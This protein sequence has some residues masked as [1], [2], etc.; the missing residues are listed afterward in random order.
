MSEYLVRTTSGR[1]WPAIPRDKLAETLTI[2]GREC[3]PV[4]GSNHLRL[5]CGDADITFT[6]EA[7]GWQ[8]SVDGHLDDPD[9]FVERITEQVSEAVGQPCE[10]IAVR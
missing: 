2:E 9:G 3:Q 8:I 5:R 7:V 1:D 4:D 10:W 6:I